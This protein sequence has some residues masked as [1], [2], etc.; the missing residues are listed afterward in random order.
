MSKH[1]KVDIFI[2]LRK[3]NGQFPHVHQQ[4]AF[5]LAEDDHHNGEKALASHVWEAVSKTGDAVVIIF[6][7][8]GVWLDKTLKSD[9]LKDVGIK[10]Y[11]GWLSNGYLSKMTQEGGE[12]QRLKLPS[13]PPSAGRTN[14]GKFSLLPIQAILS[15]S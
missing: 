4:P 7:G 1:V 12:G 13:V 15:Q 8:G 6:H 11:P 3:A 14:P 10:R 9:A 2:S 5:T